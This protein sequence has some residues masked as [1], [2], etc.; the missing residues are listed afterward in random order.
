MGLA[1]LSSEEGETVTSDARE[2]S[3]AWKGT[4][5]ARFP[6]P[7]L[8]SGGADS[9]AARGLFGGPAPGFQNL[10][11]QA[12]TSAGEMQPEGALTPSLRASARLLPSLLASL[13]IIKWGQQ[14]A[15]TV[16]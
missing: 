7:A 3:E 1:P 13:R 9:G 6:L 14:S 10:P 15:M 16:N 4:L 8:P 5:S 12:A 11:E 2:E